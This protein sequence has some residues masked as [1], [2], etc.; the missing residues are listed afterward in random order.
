MSILLAIRIFS[1]LFCTSLAKVHGG[2][3]LIRPAW[4][5]WFRHIHIPWRHSRNTYFHPLVVVDLPKF[6]SN[7]ASIHEGGSWELTKSFQYKSFTSSFQTRHAQAQSRRSCRL[8]MPSCLQITQV[9]SVIK[10][11]LDRAYNV[12]ITSCLALHRKKF[13][14]F[15]PRIC[16]IRC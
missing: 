8:L 2:G 16:H 1:T 7:L 9:L 12:G 11:R 10:C 5:T 14:R 4:S 6:L 13:R 15:G 3:G